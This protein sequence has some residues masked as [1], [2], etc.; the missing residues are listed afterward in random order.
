MP[1]AISVSSTGRE[2]GYIMIALLL[3]MVVG[4]SSFVLAGLSNRQSAYLA[5]QKELH[6]QMEEAKAALLAY[7]ANSSNLYSD[8]RGPGFFPCPD[9]DKDGQPQATCN[10]NT[11]RIGRLPE[12]EN[13]SGTYFRFNDTYKGTDQQF[14]Y[15]VGPRY[16]YDTATASNRRSR[17]RTSTSLSAATSYRLKLDGTTGYVAFIIAPGEALGTQDRATGATSYA[18]YLDGNNGDNGFDFY[19]SDSTSPELFNDQILGITLDEY[20]VAVGAAVAR[21]MKT[22]IDAYAAN[23]LTGNGS[24]PSDSGS[25]T[26]TSCPT[27]SSG[28]TFSNLFDA[29]HVWLRDGYGT[30]AGNGNNNE[31]WSCPSGVYWNRLS[32]TSTGELKFNGCTNLKFTMTYGGGIVRSGNGC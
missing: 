30:S 22:V 9:T 17:N 7:A 25:L 14:W 24:Y 29:Q 21:D 19:T 1:K 5:Q 20:M 8:A 6:I 31:R 26:S 23:P 10:S 12:Y 27:S 4:G 2:D 15:V 16:V 13:F 28:T 11:A 32:V 18:N 3:I